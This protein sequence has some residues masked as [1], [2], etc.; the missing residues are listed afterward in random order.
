MKPIAKRFIPILLGAT[1][2]LASFA[3][4]AAE[5]PTDTVR[6]VVPYAPGGTTDVLSRKVADLLQKEIGTV[7]V[8]NRPGAGSTMATGQLARGGRGADHTIAMASPG[9]TIGPVI[10][11]NLPYDPVKDFKFI[12]NVIEIP[13]VMVVP[14]S[15]PYNSVE[16]FIKAAKEKEMT[17]SSAGVGSSIHMSG[18]LFKAMTNSNMTHVPFR[19]SGEALPALL[20]GDVDVS[21]ENMPAVLSHIKSG[22]LRALAVTSA[23][24]SPHLPG[25][26]PLSKLGADLGLGD[27]VTTAWFGLVADDSMPDEG[28]QALQDALDKQLDNQSFKDFVAQLGGELATEEGDAFRDYVADDVKR[29]QRVAGQAELGQ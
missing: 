13:N 17:F 12:R 9:H 20:S 7:V 14:A 26:E 27:F 4:Q 15:S 6:L 29:W 3:V 21:F 16:E 25:V 2:P 22:K 8:E 10:Y 5:W 28:V 19:G 18:E 24:P 11:K 23:E 1:L